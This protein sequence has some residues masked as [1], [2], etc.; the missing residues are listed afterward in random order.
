[1]EKKPRLLTFTSSSYNKNNI[2]T[3]KQENINYNQEK[4]TVDGNRPR[5]QKDVE[6]AIIKNFNNF[7]EM[8]DIMDKEMRDV[9]REINTI[10]ENE[11]E[12]VKLQNNS[13]LSFKSL[14]NFNRRKDQAT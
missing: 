2:C 6:I 9:I 5:N 14:D 10:E 4:N 7:K 12:I 13:T 3:K 11:M 1:M 8:M